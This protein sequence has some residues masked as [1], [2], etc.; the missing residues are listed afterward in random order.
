FNAPVS[1][2]LPPLEL[3]DD[4]ENLLLTWIDEA[5]DFHVVQT[6]AEVPEAQRQN[7]R[8]VLAT[9]EDGTG[10]LVYVADLRTKQPDGT[11]AV[12]SMPRAEW[13]ELGAD[14]R[15][16]RME[17]L[18]PSAASAGHRTTDNAPAPT[19]ADGAVRVSAIIYGAAW[20]KPCHDAEALL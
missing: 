2:S 17:A 14:R 10:Q 13:N 9:R 5:G 3:R 19:S 20:C 12:R 18:A 7:V 8:V 15:K 6:I 11:Y 4:T 16:V 1:R